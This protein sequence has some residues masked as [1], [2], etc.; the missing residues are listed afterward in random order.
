ML[1]TPA[2]PAYSMIDPGAPGGAVDHA[3]RRVR[4]RGGA[5]DMISVE[6]GPNS[7]RQPRLRVVGG[8]I[9]PRYPPLRLPLG[10]FRVRRPGR[11]SDHRNGGTSAAPGRLDRPPGHVVQRGVKGR[12][13]VI[14]IET[15]VR[16]FGPRVRARRRRCFGPASCRLPGLPI[17][18]HQSHVHDGHVIGTCRAPGRR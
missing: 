10:R 3:S 1:T 16:L 11:R 13:G 17:P 8:V 15:R 12:A 18:H 2:S 4:R 9:P 14:G 6:L 5:T 7:R